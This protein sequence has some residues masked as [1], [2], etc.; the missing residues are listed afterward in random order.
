M[1]DADRWVRQSAVRALGRVQSDPDKTIPVLI[2]ALDDRVTLQAAAIALRAFGPAAKPAIP[3]LVNAA[4]SGEEYARYHSI[5]ALAKIDPQG[6]ETLAA[7]IRA[8]GD[9]E[10]SVQSIAVRGLKP[11]GAKAGAAIPALTR[12]VRSGA[13]DHLRNAAGQALAAIDPDAAKKAAE[14]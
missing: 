2:A 14:K 7:L 10:E 3:A 8:L 12:L 11:F 13:S 4:Q 6:P 1:K 9:E 5:E